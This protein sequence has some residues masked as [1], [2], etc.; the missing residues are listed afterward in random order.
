M[1]RQLN[2]NQIQNLKTVLKFRYVTTDNL[3]R[4]ESITSNSAYSALE[5]LT[6]AG[7]LEKIYEKSY[8]LLNKSARY[9]LTQTA[10]M[11]LR[12]QADI[13][14]DDAIWKS[15]KTDGKKTPDFIDLQVALHAA[16]NG[17]VAR[18]GDKIVID[19]ALELHGAEGVIKP[20]PG[21]LVTP[22]KGKRF[23]VE[24]ADNQHLFFIRKRI[25]KYIENYESDEWEWDVYP[26]VYIIRSSASDR[27]RLR[28]FIY[29]LMEDTYLDDT[30]F[31]FHVVASVDQ[32]RI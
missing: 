30:D 11:F 8:R 5:I 12:S 6:K 27:T 4:L 3:A 25:R 28:K 19:T 29:A 21:L 10:L 13:Q 7:Y 22:K 15:R 9:F 24:V 23:F 31:T 16:Y 14:L 1:D 18:F 26:D 2:N 17:L 32:V 20:L